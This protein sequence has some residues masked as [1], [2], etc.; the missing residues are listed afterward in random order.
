MEF[1]EPVAGDGLIEQ[2][3]RDLAKKLH[4]DAGGSAEAMAELNEARKEALR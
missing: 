1:T 4:P 2:R 3:Y